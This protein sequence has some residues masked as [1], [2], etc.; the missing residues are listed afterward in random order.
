MPGLAVAAKH[1]TAE[2]QPSPLEIAVVDPLQIFVKPHL[3]RTNFVR[4]AK[5]FSLN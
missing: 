5:S 3:G 2:L 4:Q 1:L